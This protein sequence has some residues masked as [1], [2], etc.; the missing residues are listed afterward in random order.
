[1]DI[2]NQ[3]VKIGVPPRHIIFEDFNLL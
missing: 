1:M 2:A 3:F